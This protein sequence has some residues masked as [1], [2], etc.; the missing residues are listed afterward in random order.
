MAAPKGWRYCTS[1]GKDVRREAA[2]IKRGFAGA[3]IF[4]AMV[5]GPVAEATCA[6]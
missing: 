4:L 6:G 1:L 2:M 5:V 3:V